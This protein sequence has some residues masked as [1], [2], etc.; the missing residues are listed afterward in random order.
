MKTQIQ[1]ADLV[2]AETFSGLEKQA[3]AVKTKKEGSS[4][5]AARIRKQLIAFENARY[6]LMTILMT[7]QSCI[8][9]IAC[10]YILQNNAPTPLLM[11]CAA[12]TMGSNAMFI[13]QANAKWCLGAFYLSVLVNSILILSNL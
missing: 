12:I 13:A 1:S 7:A 9:S 11:I 10:M 6:A 5:L 4:V 2:Q 3:K 8:G